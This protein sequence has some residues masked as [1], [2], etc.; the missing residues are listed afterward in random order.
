LYRESAEVALAPGQTRTLSLPAWKADSTGEYPLIAFT[1][2][3]GDRHPTNDTLRDR[4]F[5]RRGT[6]AMSSQTTAHMAI[7]LFIIVGNVAFIITR[8][9]KP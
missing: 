1:K 3:A 2:L 4:G 5:R 9:R 7:M 6:E 8:R